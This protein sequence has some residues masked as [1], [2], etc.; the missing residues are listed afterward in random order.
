[1]RAFNLYHTSDPVAALQC[2][3]PWLEDFVVSSFHY[4]P[5]YGTLDHN[6]QAKINRPTNALAH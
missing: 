5:V 6:I 2:V 1:M 3:S 4:H